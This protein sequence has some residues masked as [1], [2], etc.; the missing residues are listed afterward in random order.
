MIFPWYTNDD[1]LW[2]SYIL[3]GLWHH[4]YHV[5]MLNSGRKIEENKIQISLLSYPNSPFIPMCRWFILPCIPYKLRQIVHDSIFPKALGPRRPLR[6]ALPAVL[7]GAQRNDAAGA[8]GS[9][10]GGGRG[11][12]SRGVRPGARGSHLGLRDLAAKLFNEIGMSS[13]WNYSTKSIQT[14]FD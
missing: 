13:V 14:V 12:G 1:V 7:R 9:K 10:A 8:V 3:Q 6:S 5:S 11:G 4:V 2:F